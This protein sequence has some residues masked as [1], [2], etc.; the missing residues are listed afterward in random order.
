MRSSSDEAPNRAM[1]LWDRKM[2]HVE[3]MPD[4]NVGKANVLIMSE[5]GVNCRL[6]KGRLVESTAS[7]HSKFGTRASRRLRAQ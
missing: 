7:F 4:R 1:E 2:G 5:H 6:P 3:T